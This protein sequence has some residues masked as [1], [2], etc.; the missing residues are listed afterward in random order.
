MYPHD[1]PERKREPGYFVHKTAF[2]H[3]AA[4]IGENCYIGQFCYIGPNVKMGVNNRIEG[5]ASIGTPAEHRAH[6]PNPKDLLTVK[7]ISNESEYGVRIGCNNVIRDFTTINSGTYRH[8]QIH[9]DAIMLR[10]SHLS[11]DSV[12][13][14]SVNVSCNVMIG[15]ESYIMEG[16]NLGMGTVIH[17]RQIIGSYTMFGMGSVV[18][19]KLDCTPGCVFMGNPAKFTKQNTVGLHRARIDDPTL[20]L[21]IARFRDLK[22]KRHV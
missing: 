4:E 10:G 12:L 17:Q 3:P 22:L 9:N 18:T 7:Q 1:I 21:E 6:W 2:V 20:L 19:K 13:E 16:A 14:H 15:G 8:T 11:H 5:H